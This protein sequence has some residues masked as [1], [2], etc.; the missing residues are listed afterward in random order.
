MP[1]IPLIVKQA[2]VITG[3]LVFGTCTVVIQKVIFN[4]ESEGKDGDVHKF[5][6]P[7]FQTEVMFV[8]MF[9]CLAV[10]EGM[11]IVQH[12]TRKGRPE[13][14]TR[15]LKGNINEEPAAPALPLWKQYMLAIAPA[16]CDLVATASMNI[17]LLWIPASVWQ[18]LRGSMVVFTAI[19]SRVF[20]KK[21]MCMYR[22]IGVGIVVVALCVVAVS[23]LMSPCTTPK[24]IFSYSSGHSFSSSE[25]VTTTEEVTGILLVVAAQVIQASQIVIEEALM[26]NVKLPP[27]LIVGLEGLWGG[28]V[29]SVV[30][31]IVYWIPPPIGEDTI[32]SFIM[33]GNN[34]ALAGTIVAYATAILCYNMFG[35]YVTQVTSSVIRTILEALRTACIWVTDLFIHYVITDDPAFGEVWTEWSYLQLCGFL[36]LLLGMF[37]YNG[38]VQI[39]GLFYPTAEELK[40]LNESLRKKKKEKEIN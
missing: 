14:E 2:I 10:Y 6:K 19:F 3:M 17:G 22:W 20:L 31:V 26:A 15:P 9:G 25:V 1:E 7:W 5:E 18:M 32:D 12:C 29:C 30:L 21:W 4:M 27:T 37:V 8:G 24:I 38:I 13:E 16:M 40:E 33:I 36:L 39:D 34:G 11:R 28:M 23:S 35:M